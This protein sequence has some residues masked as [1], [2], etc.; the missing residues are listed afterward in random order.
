[1]VRTDSKNVL[2]Q[3]NTWTL[4]TAVPVMQIEALKWLANGAF[5]FEV[6]GSA[7]AS[8]VIELSTNLTQWTPVRTS[9][10]SS[11]KF[12]YTN[13]GASAAP[14]RFFRAESP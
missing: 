12:Y 9:A 3:T 8:V 6:T 13:T 4:N 7:P 14:R 10:F 5:S 11:G 1:M 2:K